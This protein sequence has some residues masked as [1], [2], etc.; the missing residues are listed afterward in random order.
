MTKLELVQIYFLLVMFI[1]IFITFPCGILGQ[2]W[3]VIV[4]FPDLCRISYLECPQMQRNWRRPVWRPYWLSFIGQIPYSNLG[5]CMMEAITAPLLDS[6]CSLTMTCRCIH[7]QHMKMASLVKGEKDYIKYMNFN[8]ISC[9]SMFRT[10]AQKEDIKHLN[11][12]S[13]SIFNISAV[14][15]V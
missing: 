12:K 9:F 5:V 3:Y 4:S 8:F 1:V 2:V 11:L 15:L 13:Y 10:H 7:T 14:L 6:R